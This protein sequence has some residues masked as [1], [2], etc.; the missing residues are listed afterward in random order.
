VADPTSGGG[1]GWAVAST[2]T[3]YA[4]GWT[5]PMTIFYV[6]VIFSVAMGGTSLVLFL[7]DRMTA[8]WLAWGALVAGQAVINVLL[9]GWWGLLWTV[10]PVGSGVVVTRSMRRRRRELEALKAQ[11]RANERRRAAAR[12]ALNPEDGQ[13]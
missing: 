2:P 11:F 8:G 1:G 12:A 6:W 10:P 5:W 13:P 7:R 4:V 3:P 9:Y